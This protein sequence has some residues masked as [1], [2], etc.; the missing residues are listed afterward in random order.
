MKKVK[1]HISE[2]PHCK[3]LES[4]SSIFIPIM[5]DSMTAESVIETDIIFNWETIVGKDISLFCNPI[6]TSLDYKE[7]YRILHVE[8]PV[9]GFALELQHKENY[10]LEKINSFLGYNAV[11]KII[12]EQNANMQIHTQGLSEIPIIKGTLSEEDKEYL[13]EITNEIK[14][15]KL[16]EILMKIGKNII[17]SSKENKKC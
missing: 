3:E 10:I 17:L 5:K 14:D 15:E 16:K 11:K 2:E 8:V 6:K 4:F 12:I 13:K 1:I 9:G 7:K